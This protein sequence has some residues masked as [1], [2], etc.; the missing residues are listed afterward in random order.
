MT[1]TSPRLVSCVFV[2][3][4]TVAPVPLRAHA[5]RAAAR[6]TAEQFAHA[7]DE[8]A[9]AAQALWAALSPEQQKVVRF[10]F[11]DDERLNFHFVPRPRQGLPWGQMSPTQRLL[12]HRLLST[13]LSRRTYGEVTT[14]MSLEEILAGIEQ[15]RGPKRDPDLYYFTVF[16]TPGPDAAWGWRAEGHHLSLNFTIVSGKGIA[17]APAFLG[18]NP[19]EVRDGPR[20]G[21]RVLAAEQDMGFALVRTLDDAQRK[22]AVFAEKA[23]DD[24]LTRNHRKADVSKQPPGIGYAELRAEQQA[25][26]KALLHVY[27]HRMREE[28]A[29]ADLAAIE[30]AGWDKV[31]FAWAGGTELGVGHYYR[32]NGPTFLIEY[33]NTQNGAN[34]VHTVWRDLR[35][36]FGED[37][38]KAHYDASHQKTD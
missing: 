3:L 37:L 16:G 34:H 4:C 31:R 5:E 36:D 27:A 18:S 14:I 9:R 22:T 1:Y 25:M 8:M 21:L 12:A 13:G 7:S 24:I 2:V 26:L 20:K 6:P 33:D 32:I 23:P 35:N 15:R 38:L 29:H 19:G 11:A 17:G 30:E 10:E 28:L